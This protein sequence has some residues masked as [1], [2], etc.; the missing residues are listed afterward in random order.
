MNRISGET[1]FV[2]AEHEATNS[3]IGVNKK[4]QVL[5]VNVNG[6]TIIPYIL[7]TLNTTELAFKLASRGNLPG[8]DKGVEF[9]TQLANNDSDPLV[10]V[11]RVVKNFM[12][13]NM[14]Q[15]AT[16]FL[17]DGLKENKQEQGHLQTCL[18]ELNLIHAPQVA[19]AI[20][21]NEMFTHYDRPR[22]ANLCEK[23]AL[24]HYEDL[25]DTKRA[26]VHT[27]VLQT[28]WLVNYFSRLTTEQS[29]AFMQEMLCINIRQNLQIV[30]QIA[31]KYSD[32]LG[33]VKL[34]EMFASF[35]TFEGL[36]YYLGSIVNLSEDPEVHF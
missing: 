5:S 17:L 7:T 3:I 27:N 13:Q 11:K 30:I 34:I 18:L 22:I 26:I 29:M 32:V 28:E 10:D 15:P 23:A 25:A 12:S 1:I 4:G 24:E 33:P 14:I 31:T 8:A 6:Q 35:K 19:D 2:T 21:G 20:L 9:V 36:Y 16:S